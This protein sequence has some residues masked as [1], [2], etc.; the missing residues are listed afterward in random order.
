MAVAMD[1]IYA[2]DVDTPDEQRPGL[3]F[4]FHGKASEYFGIWI[5]NILLSVITL[6]I[7]SAWAKV[8]NKRYFYGNTKLEGSSFAYLASPLQILKGR[9]IAFAFFAAYALVTT[10]WPITIW[11]FIVLMFL[12]T[13]WAIVRS[14]A[15]NAHYSAY[16]NVRF[17]FTGGLGEAFKIYIL[18]P[19]ANL[20]S[21]GG[22]IPYSAHRADRF[23]V[24]RST[25]GS[26]KMAFS[27][28]VGAYYRIYGVTLLLAWPVVLLIG[29]ISLFSIAFSLQSIGLDATEIEQ[30]MTDY[31]ALVREFLSPYAAWIPPFIIIAAILWIVG[32]SYL[33]V[34]RQ[35]YLVNNTKIG[36]HEI[37]LTLGL[38]R[39]LWIRVTN[40]IVISLSL[41]LMIPWARIRMARYQIG[42]MSLL[43]KGDLDTLIGEQQAK[44]GAYGD[45]LGEGMDLDLGLGV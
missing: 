32:S 8:R 28:E 16:R 4:S 19:M 27:G 41:G 43:A 6:G 3:P 34:Y 21:L 20:L 9:L 14:R 37:K 23:F 2:A 33:T 7:Y 40:L 13:P 22:V 36:P 35:N 25:Y 1:Q 39:V 18:L 44:T 26:T 10:F 5:V 45:E 17:G 42:Q 38:G 30:L 11:A 31:A 29:A 12:I 15:F 24:D